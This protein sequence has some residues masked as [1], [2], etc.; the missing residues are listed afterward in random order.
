M[1]GMI[2]SFIYEE[3]PEHLGVIIGWNDRRTDVYNSYKCINNISKLYY[4]VLCQDNRLHI[5]SEGLHKLYYIN[6][7]ISNFL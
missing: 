7:F 5:A 3:H 4:I 1:V 6:Y 2:V